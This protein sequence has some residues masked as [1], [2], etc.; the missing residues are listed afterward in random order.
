MTTATK[1]MDAKTRITLKNILFASDFS[2]IAENASPYALELARRFGAR[3]FAVHVRP[4]EIYGMAPPESWPILREASDFQ[5][6][7]EAMRLNDIFCEVPHV[8]IIEEGE[9]GTSSPL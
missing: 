9:S 2:A 6:K 8:S 1:A 4:L 5:A 7:E 3:I